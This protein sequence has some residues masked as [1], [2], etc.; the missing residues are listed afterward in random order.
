[1]LAVFMRD[2][3]ERQKH[4]QAAAEAAARAAAEAAAVAAQAGGE[5]PAAVPDSPDGDE[6]EQCNVAAAALLGMGAR[7]ELPAR[8]TFAA[9]LLLDADEQAKVCLGGLFTARTWCLLL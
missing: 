6:G 7:A 5:A 2:L 1:M 9:L 3:E 4:Q 8:P